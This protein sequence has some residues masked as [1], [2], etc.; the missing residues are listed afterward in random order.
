MSCEEYQS[1]KVTRRKGISCDVNECEVKKGKI[2]RC[3][4]RRV[5][6]SV[7]LN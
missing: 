5:K 4:Q 3:T 7:L 6:G 1:G 2:A